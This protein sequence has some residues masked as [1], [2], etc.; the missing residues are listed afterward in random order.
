M[1]LYEYTYDKINESWV[2][3][4]LVMETLCYTTVPFF[5]NQL[6]SLNLFTKTLA[7]IFLLHVLSQGE[8]LV[9]IRGL[10]LS[11]TIDNFC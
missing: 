10:N 5:P 7:C 3:A 2:Q 9:M 4:R 6:Y 8:N 11:Q 1:I